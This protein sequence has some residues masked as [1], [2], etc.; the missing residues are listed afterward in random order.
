MGVFSE[1]L[2]KVLILT[3]SDVATHLLEANCLKWVLRLRR[4]LDE[5]THPGRDEF[6]PRM[7]FTSVSGHLAFGV[8]MIPG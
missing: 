6:H 8:Y 2:L 3:L 4:C 5:R 7:S 1:L